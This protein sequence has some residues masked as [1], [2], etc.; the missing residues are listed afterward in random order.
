[1]SMVECWKKITEFHILGR[2]QYEIMEIFKYN[3]QLYQKKIQKN[4]EIYI[5]KE[6][7]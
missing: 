1:M 2:I 4:K 5:Y 7:K 3:T 6:I